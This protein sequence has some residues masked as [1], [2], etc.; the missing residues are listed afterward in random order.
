MGK[1]YALIGMLFFLMAPMFLSAQERPIQGNLSDDDGL[2]LIAA[3]ILIVETGLGA[4]TDFNGNYIIMASE[5]QTLR[6]SYVG[7]QPKEVKVRGQS[8]INVVLKEKTQ[9]DEMIETSMGIARRDRTLGYVIDQIK[10]KDLELA[11]DDNLLNALHGKATG[12]MISG[13]GGG[14][15]ESARIIIR[16]INSLD[17]NADNQPLFV[18]DG[19]PIDNSTF[20]VGGGVSRTM[21]NR[22]ADLNPDDIES[23]SIL[24]GGAATAL[25]GVR[26]A[27]GAVIVTTKK[28]TGGGLKVDLTSSFGF[29]NI[30]KYPETQD[31]FTQGY[32]TKGN[33]GKYDPNSFWP[34]W[35]S[36]VE[37]ARA[38]D[39]T[40]PKKLY[41]NYKNGYQQVHKW[42]H[43]LA[44]SGGDE[45]STFRLSLSN[46]DHV[47][48]IPFSNYG[49]LSARFNGSIQAT[50]K[51][52]LTAGINY[53]N[54]GGDRVNADRYNESLTYWAPRRD[55]MDYEFPDGTMKG[56][57]NDGKVGNNPVYGAKTNKFTD[58]VDRYIGNFTIQYNVTDWFN[59]RYQ[60][61]LDQYTDFRFLRA[62]GPTG[63]P[64][65]NVHEDNGLGFVTETRIRNRDINS[66]LILNF[67]HQF[68]EKLKSN[69]LVGHDLLDQSYNRVTTGGEE[70]AIWDWL[71]LNN[72]K[73]VTLS[74][75]SNLN[76]KRI[77]G[78]FGELLLEYDNTYFLTVTGR[79]DWS[80]TLPASNRSFFYPSASLSY[81]FTEQFEPFN[82]FLDYGKF[83]ISYATIGKDTDPYRL[84]TVYATDDIGA[85]TRGNTKGAPDLS[86]EKTTTF[87]TG[88]NLE[89]M[90]GRAGLEFTFYNHLSK[91]QIVPVPTSQAT[92][93]STFILNA[94]SIRNQGIEIGLDINPI[95][96]Q[97]ALWNIRFNFTSNKNKVVEIIEGVDEIFLGDSYGYSGATASLKLIPGQAYGNLY[98]TS[99]ARYNGKEG[100]TPDYSAPILIGEDGF[101]ER[102][103]D[104]LILGNTQ[105]KWF[106]SVSTRFA[107]G[108]FEISAL[109]DTRQGVQKYNQMSNFMSA[110]GISPFTEDRNTMVVFEGVTADGSPNTKSV[111]KGQGVGPD[112]NNYGAGYYRNVYRGI[113][114]NFI[115]EADWVRLRNLT[116]SY[117]LP[118]SILA[119]IPVSNIRI[120][121]VGHNLWLSTPFTGFDPE[122]NRGNGNADDG[123]GGFT[124]PSVRSFTFSINV[125][126]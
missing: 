25:Y 57:R 115:E 97:K 84:S 76:N 83:R 92:G 17:P 86:P 123:F 118:Q 45:K 30:N 66:N 54:S 110:F 52:K 120:S 23:M 15:G 29:E 68:T 36:T 73:P 121:G 85:F 114:E 105:P 99:Y 75:T 53:I 4:V 1:L 27:N 80:S 9:L 126:F 124:Y 13:S 32:F 39:P 89:A 40:H 79:N 107:F 38:Q 109:F 63:I 49:N 60:A 113:T 50:E 70:L 82:G 51:I 47:G 112:G 55:V 12:V 125:T 33:N 5:G 64:G 90:G 65:E 37:E 67:N 35:G 3:N 46:L 77:V 96:S 81:V 94:G 87:E 119:N 8:E 14:P 98:G 56:Y 10:S 44:M 74:S 95:I 72:V 108:N 2:P 20:T 116:L 88:F 48:V 71:S 100:I 11:V 78:A 104:Q 69:F 61:G 102:N 6:F 111:F 34:S 59:I 41:N 117:K 91:D 43:T 28:G 101:P 58:D 122:G 42:R 18:V 62:P 106:G 26:A 93:F 22:V 21:S 24:K 19:V 7:Y 103:R 16:G 31:M